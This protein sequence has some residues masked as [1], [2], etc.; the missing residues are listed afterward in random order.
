MRR[1]HRKEGRLTHDL[2]RFVR[3]NARRSDTHKGGNMT[4]RFTT[5]IALLVIASGVLASALAQPAGRVVFA[6]AGIDEH[7]DPAAT[8]FANNLA[9]YQNLY[10]TLTRPVSG[11][12]EIEGDLAERWETNSDYSEYVF[13]L[14]PGVQWHHGWG[15]V[16]AE[17]VRY[18]FER[19][20]DDD[21][22]SMYRSEAELIETIEVIDEYTIRFAL[23]GP[24][25]VFPWRVSAKTHFVGGIVPR[26]YIEEVGLSEFRRNPIGS[27]PFSF[28]SMVP[29]ERVVLEANTE[30]WEGS[31]TIQFLE[32]VGMPDATVAGL[33]TARGEVHVAA[34]PDFDVVEQYLD[35][36]NVRVVSAPGGSSTQ[37]WLN[38]L[39]PPLDNPLVRRAM[40]HAIDYEE[41]L[42][43]VYLGYGESPT[44]GMLPSL[45]DGFL[46]DLPEVAYDPEL[47]RELLAE[48]GFPDG[49]STS[50]VCTSTSF[51]Q[52]Q[53]ELV[54]EHFRAVGI[55]L[56]IQFLDRSGMVEIRPRDT[57]PIIQMGISIRPDPLQWMIWHHGRTVPPQGV[58]FMR[59]T[60]ADE[61]I[62]AVENATTPEDRIAA[63]Q[64]FQ[65]LYAEDVPG[66]PLAHGDLT[67]LVHESVVDYVMEAP[68]GIRGELLRLRD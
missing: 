67:H 50:M 27:G 63:I 54:Q 15:E 8:T 36:P 21:V 48:A 2:A 41:I 20:L 23:R 7:L 33:A 47:A 34:V 30:Y 29:R 5:L 32:L 31:P 44:E 3:P 46:T 17:D 66:L 37:L 35:H 16:T 4:R 25:L 45:S 42:F 58:N 51:T 62:D 59:W 56:D 24:D 13:Y 9:I 14:R 18:S 38:Q 19:H 43:G 49:F 22:G 28:V 12:H 1:N 40:R 10:S 64:D 53:C 6:Q 57:T 60:A 68:F 61:I 52:R 55:E 65:R 26:A 11:G 39:V